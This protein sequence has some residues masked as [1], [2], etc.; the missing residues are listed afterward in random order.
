MII[1]DDHP[2][3]PR[4]RPGRVMMPTMKYAVVRDYLADLV[5]TRLSPGDPVPSER[6]LVERFGVSRTTVRQGIDALVA[7]GL[8]ERR[9]GSGTYVAPP[10]VDVQSRITGF[11]QE[12]RQRGMIPA[13]RLL[14]AEQLPAPPDVAAWLGI[15]TRDPVH[16]VHRVRLADGVPM[17]VEQTWISTALV[18]RLLADGVPTSLYEA[19]AVAGLAPTWG[20]DSIEAV[21]AGQTLAEL[22]EVSR[23]APLLRIGRRTYADDLAV[24]YARTWYRG[25]RYTLWVPI[26]SPRRTL[27]PPR[28]QTGV[29]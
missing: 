15:K 28:R 17:A 7:D 20:E 11:T 6:E 16:Y 2:S 21:V 27:Y 26:S 9:Q 4:A 29:R 25:D 22:L 8:L 12:M 19:L 23:E 18:P 3:S 14:Q 13:S 10:K 5:A 24:S 1:H